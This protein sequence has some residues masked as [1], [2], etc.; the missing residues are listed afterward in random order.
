MVVDRAMARGKDVGNLFVS[1]ALNHPMKNLAFSR[2]EAYL[3]QI[4]RCRNRAGRCLPQFGERFAE[5]KRSGWPANTES[6]PGI[7]IRTAQSDV[8]SII[9]RIPWLEIVK[10]AYAAQPHG[11]GRGLTKVS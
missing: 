8:C 2:R 10:R 1:L 9:A 7:R 11:R 5:A 3:L 4:V 6:S